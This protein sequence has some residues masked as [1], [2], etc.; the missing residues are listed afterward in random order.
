[1]KKIIAAFD[2]LKFSEST[3]EYAV[4]LASISNA[5]LVGVFLEDISYTS[6]KIYE[7]V[8]GEGVSVKKQSELDGKDAET[9]KHSVR[10]F[11]A[12]C[13]KAGLNYTVHHGKH[14]AIDE[15]LHESIYSDALIIDS[16][17]TLIH[18]EEKT[19]TR[20]IQHVL[21]KA[22]CPVIVVPDKYKTIE[23]IILLYDGAPSS[24]YATKMF[25]YIFHSVK[26]LPVD[27]LSVKSQNQSLHLPDNKL[28]KEFMKR[29][30]PNATYTVLK[31]EASSKILLYLRTQH[32]NSL[33]VLGAYSRGALSRL[34]EE[35][36]GDIL[37]KNIHMPLFITR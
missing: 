14:Y 17:E 7:L 34:I 27:V 30:Y 13:R 35:S 12:A 31:G 10:I 8:D 15:L 2:G 22:H 29:H 32:Q 19:P 28:M 37:M 23:K 3:K 16:N 20:F 18:Y 26:D 11:E 9:R 5:H 25:S 24:V 33:I 6:Y 4:H 21:A 1:M 36:R